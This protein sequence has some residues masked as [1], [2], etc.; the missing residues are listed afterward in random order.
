M[1]IYR[2]VTSQDKV[3]EGEAKDIVA[4]MASRDHHTADPW[5][6]MQKVKE[7]HAEL[8]CQEIRCPNTYT[9]FLQ[10]LKDN[11]YIKKFEAVE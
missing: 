10:A 1:I 11:G 6:Y 3:Y 8:C 5:K 9:D 2:V 4:E 7:R